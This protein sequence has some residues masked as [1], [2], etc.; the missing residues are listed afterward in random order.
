[1]KFIITLI[2]IFAVHVVLAQR[3]VGLSELKDAALQHSNAIKN[4]TLKEGLAEADLAAAKAQYLP[5]VS[6]IGAGVYGLKDFVP[7]IPTL[8]PKGVD[9]FYVVGATATE[10]LYAGGRVATANELARLQVDVNRIL[11]RQS[12]DSVRLLTEQKY[13][14]L[15]NIQEQF[16]VLE[17]NQK[18]LATVLKQQQDM[19][20]AGLIARNDLL[21]VNVQQNQ[22]KLNR[23]KLNNGR[24]L[25]L[26]DLC[27]YTGLSYD[28]SMTMRDTL[29]VETLLSI[30]SLS[31]DTSLSSNFNYQLLQRKLAAE[32]LQ[33]RIAKGENLP[34]LTAGINAVQI[35]T[36]DNGL[37][38]KFVP[39]LTAM[40][41]IPI[42]DG[43]W[44]K[45]RQKIR[46]Q[47]IREQVARNDLA[48]GEDQLKLLIMKTWYEMKNALTE[49]SVTREN[50]V[51]AAENLKVNDDNY[52]AGLIS[53][54]EYL[55][56]QTSYQQASSNLVSS[57]AAFESKKASYQHAV[58]NAD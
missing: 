38:S 19:L 29:G 40:V 23:V 47:E 14:N 55:D 10:T 8:L 12:A 4:G 56:A 18:L 51:Q 32:S 33:K 22:L 41:S 28:S 45:G 7:A 30:H 15:V 48:H 26:L 54:S 53:I 16:K 13:W 17:A 39:T 6:A 36:I 58:G 49:I 11:S 52:K 27:F 3:T 5:S 37:G 2:S 43:L 20:N 34:S 21:K 57:F 1:M 31:P 42:S 24:N 25:A 46:Q 44:A 35:G 50:L 9:N